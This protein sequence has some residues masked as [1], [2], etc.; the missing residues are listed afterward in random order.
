MIRTLYTDS[1][2]IPYD[3]VPGPYS[4]KIYCNRTDPPS[5]LGECETD[6]KEPLCVE[7]IAGGVRCEG[8]NNTFIMDHVCI[9]NGLSLRKAVFNRSCSSSKRH[10]SRWEDCGWETRSLY[11]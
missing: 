4:Y 6:D 1:V 10:Y 7:M 5:T 8:N 9:Y 11:Q 3:D 2:E